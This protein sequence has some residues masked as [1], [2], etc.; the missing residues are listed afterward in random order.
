MQ[1]ALDHLAM[2]NS[3]RLGPGHGRPPNGI[4]A[5]VEALLLPS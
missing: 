2:P 3:D 1:L 4:S 5:F